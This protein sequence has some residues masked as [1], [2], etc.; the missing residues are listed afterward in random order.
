VLLTEPLCGKKEDKLLMKEELVS[1]A[2][3][4]GKKVQIL[5]QL[6]MKEELV[7]LGGRWAPSVLSLLALLVQ[8][9]KY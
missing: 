2:C 1:L 8:R 9:Y 7:S 5:T 4:T 6:L 3:F